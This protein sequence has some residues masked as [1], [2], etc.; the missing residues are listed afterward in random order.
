MARSDPQINIRIPAELKEQIEAA[1]AENKRSMIAEIV[2][3]LEQ[4]FSGQALQPLDTDVLKDAVK[5]AFREM[6][7]ERL[8]LRDNEWREAGPPIEEHQQKRVV[9]RTKSKTDTK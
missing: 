2:A 7:P 9:R 5:E 4:S 1:A 6:F 3:R 8:G